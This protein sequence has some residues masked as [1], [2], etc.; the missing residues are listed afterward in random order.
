[1]TT[2]VPLEGNGHID[3]IYT[4]FWTKNN[5]LNTCPDVMI[6]DTI[7]YKY[8][9]PAFWFFTSAQDGQIKKKNRHNVV[10]SKILEAFT[11]GKHRA[12]EVV[13]YYISSEV[14]NGTARCE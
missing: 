6:P 1:M 9:Q 14:R 11:K 12:C 2:S 13:A 7:V 10:N 3:N 8:R 5:R 4:Y